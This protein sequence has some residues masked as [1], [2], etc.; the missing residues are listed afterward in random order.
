MPVVA[1]AVRQRVAGGQPAVPVVPVPVVVV[2]AWQGLPL[3]QT[4]VVAVEV[5]ERQALAVAPATKVL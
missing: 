3:L 5:A 1:V 4:T 2:L